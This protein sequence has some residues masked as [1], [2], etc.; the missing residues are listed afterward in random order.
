MAESAEGVGLCSGQGFE[1]PKIRAEQF[2]REGGSPAFAPCP[3]TDPPPVIRM[4]AGGTVRL[5]FRV[6]GY[7]LPQVTPPLPDLREPLDR[8]RDGHQSATTKFDARGAREGGWGGG[9][10]PLPC[11]R[12]PHR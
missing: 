5:S 6:K 11:P 8:G 9:Q 7:P 3:E 12:R 2:R 10:V 4:V 1:M